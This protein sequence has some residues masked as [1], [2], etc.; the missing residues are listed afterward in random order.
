MK[1]GEKILSI[2]ILAMFVLLTLCMVKTSNVGRRLSKI[3]VEPQHSC[4]MWV[5]AACVLIVPLN[6]NEANFTNTGIKQDQ[7]R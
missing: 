6:A 4:N 1:K 3:E 7:L 2:V 5:P